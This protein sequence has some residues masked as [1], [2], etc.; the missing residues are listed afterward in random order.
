MS[1]DLITESDRLI[2]PELVS[3]DEIQEA[4]LR[5]R[6]L[7]EYIG[8]RRVV[9]KLKVFLE[10]ARRRNE[11]MDHTLFCGPPGLGK[12]T[13]ANIMAQELNVN[14]R[15]TSGPIIEKA[16]DLAAILTNLEAKDVLVYR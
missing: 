13:L 8:Q 7:Q 14:I 11:A 9:N 15:S 6:Q 16:G 1:E 2:T 5:P 3:E 12:T 10:A 4:S